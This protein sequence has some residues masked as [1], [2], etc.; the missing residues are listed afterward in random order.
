MLPPDL[1]TELRALWDEFEAGLTREA[2]FANALDRFSGLLQ[3]WGGGD[4]GTWRTHAVTR[5]A[6]LRRM[7]P[8]RD[9]APALWPFVVDVVDA[10]SAA[11][12][13]AEDV[14]SPRTD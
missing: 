14:G 5:T 13:I 8:I 6:V 10:A 11:G 2:R 9:G 7:E 3:N 12:F 1:E 4:G